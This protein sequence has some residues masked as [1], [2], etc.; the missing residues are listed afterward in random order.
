MDKYRR[1]KFESWFLMHHGSRAKYLLD[2]VTAGPFSGDYR[3]GVVQSAWNVWMAAIDAV[4][5][6]PNASGKPTET[7]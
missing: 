3:D 7:A 5:P 2:R 4:S 6:Q 1:D